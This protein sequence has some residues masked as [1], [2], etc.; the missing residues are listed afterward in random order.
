LF[1]LSNLIIFYFSFTKY[2]DN[3]N[4]SE[5]NCESALFVYEIIDVNCED[6]DSNTVL[7]KGM[8][9]RFILSFINFFVQDLAD[10]F[11]Y[12]IYHKAGVHSV[13]IPWLEEAKLSLNNIG[14][15]F[16]FKIFK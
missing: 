4:G 8:N 15:L 10:P 14:I 7:T 13:F 5:S 1:F 12:F 9:K 6:I 3:L 16:Y 2:Y 11:R